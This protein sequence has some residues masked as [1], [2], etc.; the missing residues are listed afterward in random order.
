L[1]AVANLIL[2]DGTSVVFEGMVE[3]VRGSKVRLAF[4]LRHTQSLLARSLIRH[5]QPNYMMVGDGDQQYSFTLGLFAALVTSKR[6][7]LE[8][9][10]L[11]CFLLCKCL[12]IN[13]Q[14]LLSKDKKTYTTF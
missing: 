2:I 14:T 3:M 13:I 5:Y 12:A 4:G 7:N 1:S 10:Q 8:G 6:E 9:Q 11:G